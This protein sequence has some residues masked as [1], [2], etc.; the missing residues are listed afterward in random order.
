MAH[1][2]VVTAAALNSDLLATLSALS[3]Q[4][5]AVVDYASAAA[6]A[7]E[8]ASHLIWPVAAVAGRSLA[9]FFGVGFLA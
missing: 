9:V 6:I 1:C 4:G 3:P 5:G 2:S 8:R 7:G